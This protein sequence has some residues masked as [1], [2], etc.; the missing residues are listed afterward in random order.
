MD[1]F[2]GARYHSLIAALSKKVPSMAIAWHEKYA[3]L[4]HYF[5]LDDAVLDARDN[6]SIL[7]MVDRVRD[8][9]ENRTTIKA[10]IDDKLPSVIQ[11]VE[12]SGRL[13]AEAIL[14]ALG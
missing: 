11:A 8:L 2:I 13:L 14:E 3:E 10:K 7:E 9:F 1:F 6:T 4:F 5:A 12:A